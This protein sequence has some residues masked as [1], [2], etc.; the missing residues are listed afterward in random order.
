MSTMLYLLSEMNKVTGK[1]EGTS[2][3]SRTT[4]AGR[5]VTLACPFFFFLRRF[6]SLQFTQAPET[7]EWAVPSVLALHFV[8]TQA[9][10]PHHRQFPCSTCCRRVLKRRSADSSHSNACLENAVDARSHRKRWNQ[11]IAL[12][13]HF[14]RTSP[15]IDAKKGLLSL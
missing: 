7:P 11:L 2:E 9:R 4:A 12:G 10:H 1:K 14:R 15:W 8:L 5:S 3:R 6:S 13:S